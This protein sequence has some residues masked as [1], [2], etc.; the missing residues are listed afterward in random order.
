MAELSSFPHSSLTIF[1]R[2]TLSHV[3]SFHPSSPFVKGARGIPSLAHKHVSTNYEV[4]NEVKCK[5]FNEVNNENRKSIFYLNISS[6]RI[7]V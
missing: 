2:K 4:I 3:P 5:A 1:V 7:S 6:V